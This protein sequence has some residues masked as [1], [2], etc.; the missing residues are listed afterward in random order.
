ML[1]DF[2][3][4]NM[5]YGMR[6]N[7]NQEWMFFNRDY[8]PIGWS[9]TK[10]TG[11]EPEDTTFDDI[12]VYARYKNVPESFLL[13]LSISG[14]RSLKRNS[15]GEIIEVNFYNDETNPQ[16]NSQ[17]WNQYFTVLQHLSKLEIRRAQF[18]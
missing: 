11:G 5:P 15:K 18:A 12:P 4:V 10:R 6:R 17:Y 8:M 13:K 1:T 2:F 16:K 9:S 14:E 7:E 3:R